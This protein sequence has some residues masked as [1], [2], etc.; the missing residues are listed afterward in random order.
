M[1]VGIGMFVTGYTVDPITMGR[2]IEDAGFDSIWVPDH[3]VVP[4]HP[5]TKYPGAGDGIIPT[6]YG[7]MAD[8]FVLLAYVG[9]ATSRIRLATGVC[10][11]PERHPL[12]LAKAVGTLDNFSG[13]RVTL[14]VGVGWLPEETALYGTDFSTRWAYTRE[15][16]T[17]M[18]ALWEHGSASFEGKYINFPEVR[19]DPIPAQRPHPPVIIGSPGTDRT[20]DRIASWGDGWLPVMVPPSE[21]ARARTALRERCE[22]RGRDPGSI[23]ITVFVMDVTRETQEAYEEA[24]ADRIV[25]GIYNHPG[26]ALPFEQWGPTRRHALASPPPANGEVMRVL[27]QMHTLAGL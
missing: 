2:A 20:F 21:V 11:I 26:T 14:G 22:K 5:A 23:E 3:T 13:G 1:K 15:A 27:E 6:L 9:A 19:C 10:L 25:V 17:A 7:E 12:T 4:V 16:V 8:P 24:G 18:K